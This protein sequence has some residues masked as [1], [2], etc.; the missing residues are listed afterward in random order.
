MRTKE[1]YAEVFQKL[2]PRGKLFD[3]QDA[4]LFYDFS[5]AV[6]ENFSD[7]DLRCDNLLT[8]IYPT[9]TVE[10]L[11]N[12]ET[13]YGLPDS[14]SQP[15]DSEETRRKLLLA[16]YNALGGQTPAYYISLAAYLGYTI[17]ITEFNT[18]RTNI[19]KTNDVLYGEDWMWTWQVNV[20]EE[21]GIYF[22]TNQATANEKLI[23]FGNERLICFLEKYKPS[24]TLV[25][26]N[27]LPGIAYA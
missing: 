21:T 9:T 22:K 7:F 26:F 23:D 18:F 10:L 2:M 20:A 12:W 11:N 5:L 8:E 16:K 6:G 4:D 13:E 14:C 17:T 24:H 15:D 19:N 3:F 25:I 1:Q 27:Y